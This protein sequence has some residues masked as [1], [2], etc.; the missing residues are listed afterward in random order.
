MTFLHTLSSSKDPTN[1]DTPWPKHRMTKCTNLVFPIPANV[2]N[3]CYK[4]CVVLS[5]YYVFTEYSGIFLPTST[6]PDTES[7]P[8]RAAMPLCFRS[9]LLLA[10]LRAG[11]F[12]RPPRLRPAHSD[13]FCALHA[14]PLV[15]TQVE[16]MST[17]VLGYKSVSTEGCGQAIETK[18]RECTKQNMIALDSFPRPKP[19][20]AYAVLRLVRRQ[21]SWL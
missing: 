2:D 1:C 5:N 4:Q 3:S 6:S 17:V 13:C 11:V 15:A 16:S 12:L 8:S 21:R 19:S 18:F 9:L 10:P 20:A 14:R 7:V